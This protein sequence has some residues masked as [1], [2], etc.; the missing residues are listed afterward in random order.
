[1]VD[2]QFDPNGVIQVDGLSLR[3]ERDADRLTLGPGPLTFVRRANELTL[4]FRT[5]SL[6]DGTP[7]SINA[8]APLERRDVHLALSGGPIAMSQVGVVEGALG[9]T[10]VAQR[11]RCRKRRRR[12]LRRWRRPLVRYRSQGT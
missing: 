8:S 2:A 3:I 10:D 11:N 7:L 5:D 4:E 12:P 6:A 9:L 1:M